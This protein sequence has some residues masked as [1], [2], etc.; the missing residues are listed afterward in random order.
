MP[1]DKCTGSWDNNCVGGNPLAQRNYPCDSI[2]AVYYGKSALAELDQVGEAAFKKQLYK[3]VLGSALKVKSYIE[4][5]RS[6]NCFGSLVW[7]LNE[8]WPTGGWG[9]LEY[10]SEVAGQV[11]GG[12]WKPIHYWMRK[13]VFTDVLIGCGTQG[14][15]GNSLWCYVKNDSP[16]SL[17]GTLSVQAVGFSDA[18]TT[19]LFSNSSFSLGA[20]P[21]S[22][23]WIKV[24]IPSSVNPAAQFITAGFA[25]GSTLFS[26]NVFLLSPPYQLTGLSA[27]S[28]TLSVAAKPNPDQSVDITL[29]KPSSSGV[30]LFV[31]L[32]TLANG[33]FSDN[34]FVMTTSSMTVQF[35][36]F[37]VL[38]LGQL[39]SS[40]RVE[41]LGEYL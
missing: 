33:R 26:T 15:L 27:F 34:A 6:R 12:R 24:P 1:A 28:I 36:P 2:Y 4:E 10:G 22:L 41:H 11:T 18:S 21:D 3:C 37:G 20:G 40:V 23:Q 29:T 32:T 7:Q 8:I 31:T 35:I 17:A 38:D 9:S 16:Q 13:S 5:T 30:G 39:T 14:N 25:S 19:N